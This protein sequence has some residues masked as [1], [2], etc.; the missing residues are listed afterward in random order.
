MAKKENESKVLFSIGEYLEQR[1]RF[2]WRTNNI[3]AFNRL[4]SGA[5]VMRKL[6]KFTPKGLPDFFV[7]AGGQIIAL[8]VKRP[9]TETSAKTYQSKEQKIWQAGFE[10]HGGKYYVVRSKEDVQAVGL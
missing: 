1:G 6:P 8:E 7:C 3:P 10:K 2:F 4:P 5:I 9:K